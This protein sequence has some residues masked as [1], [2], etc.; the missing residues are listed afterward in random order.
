MKTLNEQI[1]EVIE[2]EPVAVFMKGTPQL[3]MCGNSHRALQ[4]LHAAGAPITAVDILPDPRIRQEL[5]SISGWP[6][7]PQV[8][9]K[10]ELIG[11]ADITEE[12]FESGELRQKL[13]DALGAGPRAGRQGRRARAR[14]ILER[15]SRLHRPA[16]RVRGSR[17]RVPDGTRT[18]GSARAPA[19]RCASHAAPRRCSRRRCAAA[20]RCLQ[21]LHGALESSRSRRRGHRGAARNRLPGSSTSAC[22]RGASS[23]QSGRS[24]EQAMPTRTGGAHSGGDVAH[25]SRTSFG[26]QRGARRPRSRAHRHLNIRYATGDR[27]G[28]ADGVVLRARV[29]DERTRSQPLGPRCRV[30]RPGRDDQL[31]L[32]VKRDEDL[33]LDVCVWRVRRVASSEHGSVA[34]HVG[35]RCVVGPRNAEERSPRL[36]ELAARRAADRRYGWRCRSRTCSQD[37]GVRGVTTRFVPAVIGR[38]ERG[39]P[40]VSARR[41]SGT[42]SRARPSPECAPDIR[43]RRTERSMLG[44]LRFAG[45]LSVPCQ[46]RPST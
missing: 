43:R 41:E 29:V 11:G 15:E 3:V 18:R 13:D 16:E 32:T 45:R 21:R 20:T 40:A 34:R 25:R 12:L 6:T 46:S 14:L 37:D 38:L 17:V 33:L 44:V 8:F 23:R 7:I 27:A 24:F 36:V 31:D 35:V 26:S 4:A 42:A 1:S 28:V 10:G 5:S 9:V 39:S 2:Q 19:R 30:R 22:E